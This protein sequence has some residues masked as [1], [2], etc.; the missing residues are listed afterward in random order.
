MTPENFAPLCHSLARIAPCP[1]HLGEAFRAALARIAPNGHHWPTDIGTLDDTHY[2]LL[3]TAL[4]IA[5]RETLGADFTE[6]VESA[7][8]MLYAELAEYAIAVRR[9]AIPSAVTL[10]PPP[11]PPPA[12]R[13]LRPG[14]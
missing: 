14:R 7:W 12:P 4:L 13:C 5:L 6:D 2:D 1:A 9:G 8:A 11:A 10:P 3:G